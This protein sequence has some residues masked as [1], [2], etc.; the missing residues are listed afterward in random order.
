MSPRAHLR[1]GASRYS[2]ARHEGRGIRALE[3]S[4]TRG[5]K[6]SSTQALK[7]SSTQALKHSSTQALKHSN[8][9][10]LKHS[11]TQTLKH[12]NTQTLNATGLLETPSS[13]RLRMRMAPERSSAT[14]KKMAPNT[15]E[16][17]VSA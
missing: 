12:S 5:L 16:I 15:I 9:Q 13:Q 17:G 4:S 10:T 7:H 6:H 3:H 1:Q 14:K 2:S 11:N 8:T